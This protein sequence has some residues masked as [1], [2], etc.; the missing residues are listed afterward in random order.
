VSDDAC[1]L[2]RTAIAPQINDVRRHEPP[3]ATIKFRSWHPVATN[4]FGQDPP[5]IEGGTIVVVI[6]VAIA[7]GSANHQF[8]SFVPIPNR[9]VFINLRKRKKRNKKERK[10][11][12]IET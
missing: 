9:F 7:C 1:L 3:K 12:E 8:R 10:R 6:T 11:R 4:F 2:G 5:P